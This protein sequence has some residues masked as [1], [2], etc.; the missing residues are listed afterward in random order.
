M[1]QSELNR[2]TKERILDAAEELFS[3]HGYYGASIR[4]ITK[5]CNVELSLARYYFG[6]K[7]EL[8]RQAIARRADVICQ[9]ILSNLEQAEADAQGQPLSLEAIAEALV[10]EPLERMYGPEAG[11]SNY[12]RLLAQLGSLGE[13]PDLLSPLSER[14]APVFERFAAALQKALPECPRENIYW[15]LHFLHAMLGHLINDLF[16]M[17]QLSAGL[18]KPSDIKTAQAKLVR[19]A[20][21]GFLNMAKPE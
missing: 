17:E 18:C 16:L 3:R 4:Q 10:S 20:V 6:S 2:S 11:W 7:D 14:H 13:R 1:D 15:S 12:L 19:Y 9:A 5:H 21:G 8:F